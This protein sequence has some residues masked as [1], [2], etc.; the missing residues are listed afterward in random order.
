M[1][2]FPALTDTQTPPPRQRKASAEGLRLLGDYGAAYLSDFES[3][4]AKALFH[5]DGR[6]FLKA[7][8]TALGATDPA[9][10]ISNIKSGPAVGGD[11]TAALFIPDQDLGVYVD[12]HSGVHY[13]DDPNISVSGVGLF[14]RWNTR[15]RPYSGGGFNHPE[16][17]NISIDALAAAI[18]AEIGHG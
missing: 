8:Q 16:A 9:S 5:R 6:R 7:L 3:P 2:L 14:W 11:V 10:T 18:N 17:W 15:Q 1:S 12:I 13:M 4:E